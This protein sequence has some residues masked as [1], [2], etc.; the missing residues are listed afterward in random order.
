MMLS[1]DSLLL[2]DTSR[3][4]SF[5]SAVT[6]KICWRSFPERSKLVREGSDKN[7]FSFDT[8]IKLFEERFKQ[9]KFLA[10]RFPLI[11]VMWPS[12]MANDSNCGRD[13]FVRL[14]TPTSRE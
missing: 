8:F 6:L 7:V 12:V 9:A 14:N 1:Q 5:T 4:N 10:E 2:P 11:S 13:N 3:T